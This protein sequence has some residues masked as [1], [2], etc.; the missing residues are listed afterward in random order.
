MKKVEY[1]GYIIGNGEIRPGEKK[2]HAIEDFPIPNDKH[3]VRRFIGLASFFRRF[4]PKFS[5]IVWPLTNLTKNDC[6]FCWK[7]EQQK[8][9][10]LI[11]QKL[12]SK[13]V[14]KIYNPAAFA[15]ELHTDASSIGIAAMLLHKDKEKDPLRLVYAI[16][17]ATSETE[18]KY[19][20]SRLELMAVAWS[21]ERLRPL[22]IG[23]KLTW[24]TDC[25]SLIHMNVKKTKN[26]QIAR[27]M[28][29]ISEFDLE[30]KHKKGVQMQHVD[31][32]SRA[33]IENDSCSLDSVE[34][35][36][37]V[38]TTEGQ[39][40]MFQRSDPKINNFIQILKKQESERTVEEKRAV[41]DDVL[42]EGILYK[43]I[44]RNNREREVFVA[45]DA[46]RKSLAVRFHD[47]MSHFGIDKTVDLIERFY[48]FPRLR[49]YIRVHIK[50]CFVCILAK[51]KVGRGEGELHPISAGCRPFDIIH[52]DHIGPFPTSTKGN[53][54]VLGIIDNLTKFVQLYAV[55]STHVDTTVAK[56]EEFVGRFGAPNRII[57]DRGSS[58]T[59][60][61]FQAF[62]LFYAIKHTLNSS[63]HPRANGLIE[64][65]NGTLL[66]AMKISVVNGNEKHWDR[67]LQKIERDINASVSSSTGKTPFEALFGFLPRFNDNVETL[68]VEDNCNNY[69]PPNE[70]QE[71][72]RKEIEKE[73]NKYKERF[74][75]NRYNNVKYF[76]GDIV[77]MSQNPKATGES[78]KLQLPFS[79]TPLVIVKVLPSDT[80][81]VKIRCQLHWQ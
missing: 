42:R 6:S 31:A 24:Y 10:E 35:I 25:Q 29:Q 22:L 64:R 44:L 63:R 67:N 81:L 26:G 12:T 9:F 50:N 27:W 75:R 5:E 16:S 78:K 36:M 11:K 43:K 69:T 54:Y 33:P 52:T 41:Q 13:P 70:I 20:S 32:L 18:S 60:H 47:C 53:R 72:V 80:Y 57:S 21:L 65:L 58:F 3:G 7:E 73:Q 4:V 49:N 48:Y 77:S 34:S 61:V 45:P 28:S 17:R 39:I 46:M 37:S 2:I 74:D 71:N 38:D 55:K 56:F 8:S 79:E 1:L 30:V 76:I 62:C 59:A 51:K 19:H 40:V 66:T 68:I 15:T 14:L 23:I